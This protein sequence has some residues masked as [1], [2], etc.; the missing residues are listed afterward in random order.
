[1]KAIKIF[2]NY[3]ILALPAVVACMLWSSFRDA[4]AQPPATAGLRV[5]WELLS[6]NLMLWFAGL[7][8]YLLLLLFHSPTRELTIARLLNLRERDEREVFITGRASKKSY[9]ATLSLMIFLLFLSIFTLEIKRVPPQ[10]AVDGKTGV[11]SIGLKFDLFES[12]PKVSANNSYVEF[13]DLPLTKSGIILLVVLWQL[14]T[15]ALS[16]RKEQL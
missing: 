4:G 6:W 9:I 1:M 8:A 3:L 7:I 13:Q 16:A 14:G 15:F 2:Q 5:L 11:L 12:A 10:Q